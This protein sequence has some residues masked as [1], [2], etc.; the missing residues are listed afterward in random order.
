M[1]TA[2]SEREIEI[3]RESGRIVGETL[4]LLERETK[5]G[6]TT[7]D[8]DILAEEYIRSQGAVPSFLNYVPK[9]SRGVKPYPA[10]LCTSINEEV[11]HGIPS[12]KRFLKDGDIVT[13]DCGALKNGYHGD[14]ARTFLVG[15]VKP[16]VMHL[17]KATEECL[18]LAIQQAIVGKRLG[19]ISAAVQEYAESFGYGVVEDMV[20]HAVGTRMHEEPAVPNIGKR[21]TGLF[22]REGMVLAIEPMVNLG[23]TRK[24]KIGSDTW[25]AVSADGKPSAHFEHTV[26]VRKIEA[27]ILT[28]SRIKQLE[29]RQ[30]QLAAVE[31]LKPATP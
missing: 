16:D 21:S 4:D 20:G 8:L 25:T 27:E 18:R 7:K 22:L 15:E 29:Q 19:D 11:V 14:G 2:R 12:K 23:R 5:P 1:V 6:I 30:R 24:I 28:L 9:G 13:V 10:T 26:V 31:T 3:M 17:V